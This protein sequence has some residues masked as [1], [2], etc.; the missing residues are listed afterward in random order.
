MTRR[1]QARIE[2]LGGRVA[3]SVSARTDCVV[4]GAKAGS[5]LEKA[6]QLGIQVLSEEEF[7][8]IIRQ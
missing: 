2:E 1:G 8:E 5:K 6:L 4:A 3:G 7:L